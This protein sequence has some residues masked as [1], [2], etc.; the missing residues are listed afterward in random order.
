MQRL[1]VKELG[2]WREQRLLVN[3]GRCALCKLSI[4]RP[5]ADHDHA[6]GALRDVICSGC[7]AVLGKVENSYRRYGVQSLAAFL[8]GA[9]SYLQ[10]HTTNHTGLIYPTHR[11][12]DEKRERR[13]KLARERRAKG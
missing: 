1:T 9:S 7:N 12:D 5:C 6:T 13:N 3:G 4:K 8:N 2:A 11:N 10:R